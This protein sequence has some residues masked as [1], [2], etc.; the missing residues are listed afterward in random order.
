MNIH[1]FLES[2]A[3]NASRNFKIEQLEAN[4][5]NELLREVIRLALCPFTQ[6][7][8]R[9]IP[10]YTPNTTSHAASLQSMLPAFY[11]LHTRS[12]TGNAAIDHLKSM[13]EAVSPDDAKV[14][15]RIIQ[16]D[17][18]AGFSA[19]TSNKVWMGLVHELSLIHI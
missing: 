5:D 4:K 8:Q 16:K 9:K 3:A 2:L 18:R 14:I 1:Q 17:L 13:L 6:F 11:D 15:E 12:I 7:Y 10:A 19:S